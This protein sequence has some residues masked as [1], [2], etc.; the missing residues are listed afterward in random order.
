MNTVEVEGWRYAGDTSAMSDKMKAY[1][2]FTAPA[3]LSTLPA[4][5]TARGVGL[6]GGGLGVLR[7][8]P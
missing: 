5:L 4:K 6:L 2:A 7:W 8:G 1:L 3:A